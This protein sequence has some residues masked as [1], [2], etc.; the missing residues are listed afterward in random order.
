MGIPLPGIAPQLASQATR[1][2]TRCLQRLKQVHVR[3]LT[4]AAWSVFKSQNRA[5]ARQPKDGA[6]LAIF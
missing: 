6:T 3:V 2:P 4:R 1:Q 5:E